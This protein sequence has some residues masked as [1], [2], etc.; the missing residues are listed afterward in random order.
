MILANT[1]DELKMGEKR[2]QMSLES[3]TLPV[4]T[5]HPPGLPSKQGLASNSFYLLYCYILA[6]WFLPIS[7][8]IKHKPVQT[9][10]TSYAGMH[11]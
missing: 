9:Q 3:G 7:F 1:A 6:L 4:L 5:N 8:H 2:L 11:I 10:E